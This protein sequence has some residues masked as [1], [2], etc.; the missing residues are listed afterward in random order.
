VGVLPGIGRHS[1]SGWRSG[2]GVVFWAGG[3]AASLPGAV[4]HGAAAARGLL[5]RERAGLP[6]RVALGTSG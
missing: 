3:G 5:C 4:M 6:G 1:G 2:S